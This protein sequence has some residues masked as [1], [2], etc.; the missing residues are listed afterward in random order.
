MTQIDVY[1]KTK[2]I[3]DAT[4]DLYNELKE[5]LSEHVSKL[6]ERNKEELRQNSDK[7]ELLMGKLLPIGGTLLGVSVAVFVVVKFVKS[8]QANE[9]E[10]K[11]KKDAYV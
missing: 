9:D 3:T 4:N 2:E 11:V 10:K 8:R 7:R 6:L 1:P 5:K